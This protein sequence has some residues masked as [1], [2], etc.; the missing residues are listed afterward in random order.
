VRELLA[1]AVFGLGA[2]LD[3]HGARLHASNN[4]WQLTMS[5]SN[6]EWQLTM[7]DHGTMNDVCML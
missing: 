1:P 5:G 2:Q 6:T 4:E 3:V 7:S